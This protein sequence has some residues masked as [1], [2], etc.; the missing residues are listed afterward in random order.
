MLSAF[1]RACVVVSIFIVGLAPA[2]AQ[3]GSYV[4]PGE[5]LTYRV[6]YL[7]I[8]L[9]TIKTITEPYTM[10]NGKKS[11]KVKVFIDSHPNIPFVSLHAVYESWM[12]STA[13]Y[14]LKFT[15]NTE[16][17]DKQWEF[18]QYI[19]DYD[20]RKIYADKFRDKQ[21][22]KSKVFDIKKRY[23]DGS[24]ILFAARS[25]VN[26]K[27]SLRLPTVIMDDTV[28]TV[29]NFNGTR[30][31]INIDASSYPIKTVFFSGD[32]NW[33][34]IYG[35]SGRFEGW[36]SDDEARIPIKAKMKLYVGSATI[37]LLTWRRGKWQP[38]KAD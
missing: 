32:A 5:E 20:K 13:S 35:L 7:N 16:V 22:I 38:P 24:S 25:L 14:A 17:E 33:T 11:V 27:K 4:Y 37:E 8:T 15:A 21:K 10:I 9:G 28:N 36:F 6:S 29:I 31:A 19:F 3:D 30:E 34:G 18:D 2:M 26:V 12:D 1:I 23:N